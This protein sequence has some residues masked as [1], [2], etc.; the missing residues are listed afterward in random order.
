[1]VSVPDV[2]FTLVGSSHKNVYAVGIKLK[3]KR[4]QLFGVRLNCVLAF[5]I[6]NSELRVL[7]NVLEVAII[8]K[9]ADTVLNGN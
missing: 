6:T 5:S 9:Q 3:V 1:V 8:V 2:S 7:G 4:R